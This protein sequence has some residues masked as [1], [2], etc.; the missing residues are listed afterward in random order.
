MIRH[1]TVTGTFTA[2]FIAGAIRKQMT[3]PLKE[4]A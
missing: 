4:V 1:L 3:V 2:R